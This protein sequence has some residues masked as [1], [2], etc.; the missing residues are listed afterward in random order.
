MN[1]YLLTAVLAIPLLGALLT[2]LFGPADPK[3]PRAIALMS[4]IASLVAT[5]ALALTR[6]DPVASGLQLEDMVAW[7]PGL[8]ISYHVGVDGLSMAMLLLNALLCCVAVVASWNVRERPTMYFVLFQILQAGVAGVFAAQDLLLFFVA[9]ELELIPMYFLI[10]IWGG[11]R[12]EYAAMKFLL[13]TLAGSA[14]MLVAFI[15]LY[16]IASNNAD[17][18]VILSQ[19]KNALHGTALAWAELPLFL[20][21]F[22]G[23][24]VKLPSFPFHTWLPDAHV[25]ASTPISVIL[26]GILLKMGAYGLIRFNWTLFPELVKDLAPWLLALGAFNILYGALVAMRQTDMKKLIAYSSVSHMGFVLLGLAALNSAGI[27]GA[28]FQMVS[29]GLITAMLFLGVGVVYDHTHTRDIEKLGGLAERMPVAAFLMIVASLASLGLPGLS[30][31]VAEFLAFLGGFQANP[32][33]TTAAA[34]GVVLTAFYMLFMVQR[35]YFQQLKPENT[36]VVDCSLRE[37]LPQAIL[38]VLVLAIGCYPALLGHTVN[39]FVVAYMPGLG[40]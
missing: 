19:H 27:N 33:V 20:F 3:G 36:Q 25:E 34:V 38:A 11:A 2:A 17:M 18:S 32:A 28:I 26:A 35:V 16:L 13:Y 8:K 1:S 14:L 40:L 23:F 24:A 10:A 6:F 12:R 9:W 29:H 31:F 30:G 37:A 4:T 22:V 5:A 7:L 39:S 21:L 15:G